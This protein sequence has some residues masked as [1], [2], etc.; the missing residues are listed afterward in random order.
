MVAENQ[1]FAN[2]YLDLLYGK[3]VTIVLSHL[4]KIDYL[5]IIPFLVSE[6]SEQSNQVTLLDLTEIELRAGMDKWGINLRRNLLDVLYAYLISREFEVNLSCP[7]LVPLEKVDRER[8]ENTVQN[9][10]RFGEIQ[11]NIK[12]EFGLSQVIAVQSYFATHELRCLSP[13]VR[14]TKA[15]KQKAIQIL[16]EYRVHELTLEPFLDF[17]DC[18]IIQNGRWLGQN[19]SAFLAQ[20]HGKVLLFLQSGAVGRNS[21]SLYDFAPQDLEGLESW[22]SRFPPYELESDCDLDKEIGERWIHRNRTDTLSFFP[23]EVFAKKN[24]REWDLN[25]G[26]S[27]SD[28]P[29]ILLL[30]SSPSEYDYFRK[31]DFAWESQADGMRKAALLAKSLGFEVIVRFHPNQSN[32]ALIDLLDLRRALLPV[33]DRLVEPWSLESTYELVRDA[34]L[35]LV[36]ESTIGLEAATVGKKTA[37]LIKTYYSWIS[38]IPVLRNERDLT[39]WFSSE[40]ECNKKFALQACSYFNYYGQQINNSAQSEL[41]LLWADLER[42][43]QARKKDSSSL[44]YFISILRKTSF[45]RFWRLLSPSELLWLMSKVLGKNKS[46]SLLSTLFHYKNI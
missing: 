5:F 25:H 34:S 15:Q 26:N 42:L 41:S 22:L 38:R 12:L 17:T 40:E 11:S 7:L 32:Y 35:V 24:K 9:S 23:E 46:K 20:K 4:I 8:I 19:A 1:K 45:F 18:V 29:F 44:T 27:R 33:S 43:E 6:L 2:T 16:T 28:K 21:I 37:S 39:S 13:E 30:T 31:V 3:R 36:W 10:N 14:L